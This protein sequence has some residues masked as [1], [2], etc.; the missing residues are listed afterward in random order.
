M[1][2]VLVN[3]HH[4]FGKEVVRS[5]R[6]VLPVGILA[7]ATPVDEAGYK[8]K[9]IDQQI[10]PQWKR[11][12]LAELKKKPLCVGITCMTGPQIWFALEVSRIVKQN[13]NIPVVWGGMHPSLLPNQTIENENVDIVVQGEGEETFLELV[14]ALG[15]GGSLDAVKGIWYKENGQIKSNP[16][17]PFI[18]LNAQPNLAY[19]LLDIDEY[20]ERKFGTILLRTFTSRGCSYNCSFCYNTNFNRRKWRALTAEET[21]KRLKKIK[22]TY[23]VKGFIFN[24]DNFFG[25][26]NRSKEILEGIIR[27]KVDIILWKLDIRPDTLFSLDDDFLRLLKRSGCRKLTIGLESGSERMLNF[28]KKKVT[29]AQILSNNKRLHTFGITPKYSFMVGCPTETREELEQTVA[30]IWRLL[31]DNPELL[32]SVHIYTPLP[33]TEL[34]D[35]AVEHGLQVPKRL[36]DWIPFSY[37]EVN[38]PWVSEDRRKLIEMLHCCTI[39]LEKN[40]FF[41][42]TVS[43]HPFLRLLGR[44]YYPLARW[45]VKKLSY[46]FPVDIRLM[47]LIRLYRRQQPA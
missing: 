40:F 18:D 25:D 29:I 47:E 41:N 14:Q 23:N 31:K 30:L 1:N 6:T 5:Q 37:R 39:L 2:V 11:L 12:L 27:E 24:D 32:K 43:I 36:E 46:K 10:K 13:G 17:R 28:L 19:H 21:V 15:K 16:P 42:P 45:R 9:I 3:P 8:V 4:R 7:V 44:L 33:G 22:E 20:I 38:L 26:I 35:V 34:F